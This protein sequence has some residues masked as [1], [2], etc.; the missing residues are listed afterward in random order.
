V[1]GH[2]IAFS[3]KRREEKRR[4]GP[5]IRQIVATSPRS[6]A[7][8]ARRSAVASPSRTKVSSIAFVKPRQHDRLGGTV[9][10]SGE[11]ATPGAGRLQN[12]VVGS[13]LLLPVRP[14]AS[15]PMR[16]RW[17]ARGSM[18]RQYRA[19]LAPER[20]ACPPMSSSA[21]QDVFCPSAVLTT[22]ARQCCHT[23]CTLCAGDRKL[24]QGLIEPLPH[25]PWRARRSLRAPS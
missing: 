1:T 10:G 8:I 15:A 14:R 24:V 22:R 9:R 12:R 17:A 7:R 16:R 19:R 5:V 4:V 2:F 6:D 21:T 23:G 3:R 25:G 20:N 11:S 18:R 13:R